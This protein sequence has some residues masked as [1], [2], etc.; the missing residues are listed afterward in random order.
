VIYCL[1]SL[2]KVGVLPNELIPQPRRFL[3][4]MK[5]PTFRLID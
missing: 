2:R 5:F 4:P 3:T 1:M